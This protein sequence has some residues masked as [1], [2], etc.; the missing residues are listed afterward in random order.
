MRSEQSQL[1][2][3]LLAQQRI[4]NDLGNDNSVW[5]LTESWFWQILCYREYL[6]SNK[7]PAISAKPDAESWGAQLRKGCLEL[8]IL[9]TLRH[10]P[11][12]GLDILRALARSGLAVGEGTLYAILNRLRTDGFVVSE[13]RDAG[14]GHPRK[15]FTLTESGRGKTTA[16]AKAWRELSAQMETVLETNTR[17]VSHERAK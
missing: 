13:W 6:L 1:C 9:A 11:L 2:N 5:G 10:E 4:R 15:Y 3:F 17:K 16:M 7:T 12:Y 14:T 8:A